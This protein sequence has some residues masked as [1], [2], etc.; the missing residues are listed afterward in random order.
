[1]DERCKNFRNFGTKLRN[2]HRFIFELKPE[3]VTASSDFS[4]PEDTEIIQWL[5][6]LIDSV[7]KNLESYKLHLAIEDLYDFIWHKFADS[8]IEW[9]KKRRGET[10]PCLEYVFKT[11]LE[12]LHPFMPFITEELW[13]KLPHEGKSIMVTKWPEGK[14]TAK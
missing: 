8:Y 12:L 10:Q 7:T 13:Q 11:S 5:N 9:S 2:L 1:M 3:D 6:G 14:I 4:H